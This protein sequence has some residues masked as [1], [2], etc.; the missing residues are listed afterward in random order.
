M[1]RKQKPPQPP[2]P[3]GTMQVQVPPFAHPHTTVQLESPAGTI[4]V[5]VPRG[6]ASN[7]SYNESFD[8]RRPDLPTLPPGTILVTVPAGTPPGATLK[9]TAPGGQL[10]MAQV[11]PGVGPGAQFALAVPGLQ[12]NYQDYTVIPQAERHASAGELTKHPTM[13][14]RVK[15]HSMGCGDSDQYETAEKPAKDCCCIPCFCLKT[16]R[17]RADLIVKKFSPTPVDRATPGG[18]V[19]VNGRV[20]ATDGHLRA[21][22]SGRPCVYYEVRVEQWVVTEDAAMWM[23]IVRV[24]KGINFALEAGG[25]TCHVDQ[26]N[27]GLR[28]ASG[29]DYF[30]GG[31]VTADSKGLKGVNGH[32]PPE[33][34]EQIEGWL[35]ATGCVKN[36]CMGAKP[37]KGGLRVSENAFVVGEPLAICGHLERQGGKLVLAPAA[38]DSVPKEER[39]RWTSDERNAWHELLEP[40]NACGPKDFC[41]PLWIGCIPFG[42]ILTCCDCHRLTKGKRGPAVLVSNDPADLEGG[43]ADPYFEGSGAPGTATMAERETEVVAEG[44]VIGV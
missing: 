7:N 29:F 5:E 31:Y 44:V 30:V 10:V 14:A 8:V 4:R 18:V 6:A 16:N 1:G 28:A 39:S 12:K 15:S 35:R 38:R 34:F 41:I 23:P 27:A 25:V 13:I 20:F 40:A 19:K 26:V 37:W 21:P 11:P 17:Q 2:P 43:G 3:P 33:L 32:V 42:V 24:V 9:V 22:C 36:A